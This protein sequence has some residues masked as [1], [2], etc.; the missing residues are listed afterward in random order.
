M[1]FKL[2]DLSTILSETARLGGVPF[3]LCLAAIAVGVCLNPILARFTV[4]KAGGVSPVWWLVA[5]CALIVLGYYGEL[6]SYQNMSAKLAQAIPETQLKHTMRGIVYA[7]R[8][9]LLCG[10]GLAALGGLSALS[11]AGAHTLRSSSPRVMDKLRIALALEVGVAASVAISLSLQL[12]GA[13]QFGALLA[14]SIASIVLGTLALVLV[15]RVRVKDPIQQSERTMAGG[16]V[17]ML[18]MASLWGIAQCAL[19][20]GKLQSLNV[21]TRSLPGSRE[22]LTTKAMAL[23]NLDYTSVLIG[24]SVLT[25][26]GVLTLILPSLPKVLRNT[27]VRWAGFAVAVLVLCTLGLSIAFH[28]SA[29][30]TL[31][32]IEP[33]LKGIAIGQ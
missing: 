6:V 17:L 22:A 16:G 8:H 32:G 33:L 28:T 21:H 7:T 2:D 18:M 31:T 14:V 23:T 1:A 30:S 11:L 20:V 9:Q 4:K 25:G 19:A 27:N 3:Y 29:L 10:L 12:R 13:Y 24:L 5:P 26:F 15:Y